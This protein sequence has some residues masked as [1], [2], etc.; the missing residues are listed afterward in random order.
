[1]VGGRLSTALLASL[2]SGL[3]A[4]AWAAPPETALAASGGGCE[5]QGQAQFSPGLTANAQS[6]VYSFSGVLT[7]CAASDSTA[8]ATGNVGAGNVVSET[9]TVN[10]A[11]GPV[12]AT[13]QYQEP[14]PT[15]SGGCTNSTTG[16]DVF[17]VWADGT[18]T[19]ISY[20]TT[21]AAALVVLQGTVVDSVVLQPVPG[22]GITVNSVFYPA[23][24]YTFTTT[25]DA[26]DAVVGV[27]SFQPPD[28]TAC[29]TAGGVPTAG[30]GGTVELGSAP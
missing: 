7:Q 18:Q 25:R 14:R 13:F 30:I 9:V 2:S 21:G 28:P 11:G 16:G 22:Q 1:M 6:F 3:V 8:P 20:N 15:G 5:L 19:A 10:T 12:P 29:N 26:G 27:L 23:P 4:A 24:A 17:T